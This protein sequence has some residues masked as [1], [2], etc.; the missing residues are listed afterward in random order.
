M[1]IKE[2]VNKYKIIGVISN[3]KDSLNDELFV[4]DLNIKN[5]EKAY[6]MV[7]LNDISNKKIKDLSFDERFKLDFISKLD[8]DIIIIGNISNS[9]VYKEQEF[10]KKLLLKLCNDYNKKIVII[11]NKIDI[12]L[13]F[14]NNICVLEDNK[15]KYISNDLYDDNLYKYV[16]MPKIIEFV[17]YINKDNK[18]L[19]ESTDI[20]ELIKDIYRCVS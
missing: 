13:N 15:I 16:K 19:M 10:I 18:V 2:L 17:K 9:L 8:N 12:F 14:I 4:K 1:E 11:D 5:L 7:N 20:Y 6:K 3:Y